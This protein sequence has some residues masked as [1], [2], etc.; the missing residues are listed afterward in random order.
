M[1]EPKFLSIICTCG[2]MVSSLGFEPKLL[3]SNPNSDYLNC[4]SIFVNCYFS[5]HK[6]YNF[7]K[8]NQI[9]QSAHLYE[10]FNIYFYV[11]LVKY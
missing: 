6:F 1:F 2:I 9:I 4:F 5:K 11:P 10:N 3:G 7:E 8:L